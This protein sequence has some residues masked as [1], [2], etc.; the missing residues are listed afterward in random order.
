MKL[1][2]IIS[3]SCFVFFWVMFFC[4]ADIILKQLGKS[5]YGHLTDVVAIIFI[6]L[7]GLILVSIYT[8]PDNKRGAGGNSEPDTPDTCKSDTGDGER[9]SNMPIPEECK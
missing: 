2:K 8:E 7:G 4:Y 5:S 1:A 3:V 6:T 9:R